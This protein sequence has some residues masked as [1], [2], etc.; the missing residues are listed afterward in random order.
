MTSLVQVPSSGIHP[1]GSAWSPFGDMFHLRRAVTLFLW[2]MITMIGNGQLFGGRTA[3][4]SQIHIL[5]LFNYLAYCLFYKL[6]RRLWFS[7]IVHSYQLI[8]PVCVVCLFYLFFFFFI[9]FCIHFSFTEDK[10]QVSSCSI[11]CTKSSPTHNCKFKL[12]STLDHVGG[13]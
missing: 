9:Y 8:D 1:I 3:K 4:V 12:F 6:I 7:N 10:K 5:L 2:I 11:W 13:V